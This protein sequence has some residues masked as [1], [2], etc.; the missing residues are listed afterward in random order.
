MQTN[1]TF[2]KSRSKKIRPARTPL[3]RKQL[4]H[5][6]HRQ[7][8]THTPVGWSFKHQLCVWI[9]PDGS[10]VSSDPAAPPAGRRGEVPRV[11]GS[12]LSGRLCKTNRLPWKIRAKNHVMFIF[13]SS[14][15]EKGFVLVGSSFVPVQNILCIL[16]TF[17]CTLKHAVFV[18][19]EH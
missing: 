1:N 15:Q 17:L 4:F 14:L 11:L 6:F 13:G 9:Q 12:G 10:L 5:R 2:H 16:G 8:H 7:T 3:V 18:S 19:Q